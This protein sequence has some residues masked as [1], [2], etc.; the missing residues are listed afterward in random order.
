MQKELLEFVIPYQPV[1][2]VLWYWLT[3]QRARS[4]AV[5]SIEVRC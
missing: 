1:R 5:Q 4:V 3:Q 2:V